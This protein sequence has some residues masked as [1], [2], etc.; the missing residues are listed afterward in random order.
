MA[1][2]PRPVFGVASTS[3]TLNILD[4][5]PALLPGDEV[6]DLDITPRSNRH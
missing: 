1:M 5:Q 2:D 6:D 3:D 4:F